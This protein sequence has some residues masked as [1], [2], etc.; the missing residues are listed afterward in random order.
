M[1]LVSVLL[2][3]AAGLAVGYEVFGDRRPVRHRI[4][5]ALIDVMVAVMA[6]SNVTRLTTPYRTLLVVEIALFVASLIV[7]IWPG[8]RPV[9]ARK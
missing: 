9:S 5:A 4:S 1:A 6:A 7:L 3:F 8:R 2:I